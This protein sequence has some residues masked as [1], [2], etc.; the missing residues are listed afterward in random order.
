MPRY[1]KWTGIAAAILLVVS[2]FTPWVIIESKNL[3]I[4]GVDTAGTNYGRPAYIHFFFTA[5][6]LLFTLLP[7]LWAKRA[8]LLAA[9]LNLAWAARNFF[10]ITACAGGEC[11]V[12]K[13]GLLL[14]LLSSVLMLVS[15][16]FPDMELPQNR[17][18]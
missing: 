13:I 5:F 7:R 3:I 2:C 11:P 15:A 17:E 9:A 16:L 8:N 6:F 4:S 12:K 18:S 1:L 10:I 14:V